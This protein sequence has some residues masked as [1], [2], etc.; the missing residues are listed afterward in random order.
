METF[1]ETSIVSTVFRNNVAGSNVTTGAGEGGAAFFVNLN[2][3]SLSNISFTENEANGRG[4]GFF[5]LTS[6]EIFVANESSFRDNAATDG[7]GLFL[8]TVITFSNSSDTVF[9]DNDPNNIAR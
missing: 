7:G 5:A 9:E 6:N 2:R 8:D 1:D 4:G 3:L